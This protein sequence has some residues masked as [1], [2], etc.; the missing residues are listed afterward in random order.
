MYKWHILKI[1]SAFLLVSALLFS[2]STEGTSDFPKHVIIIGVDGMSP[3]GIRQAETPNMDSFIN[4]G[5]STFKA[6]AVLP[7]SS[8]TNWASMLMGAGPE[9]HG[10]TSNSWEKDDFV[11]PPVIS[12]VEEIFPTIFSVLHE[13]KPQ[14]EFGTV[15]D[16]GGF[17]RLFEKSIVKFDR[18]GKD[19]KETTK[20]AA[21]Y[22][23]KK[24][25]IYLFI[26]LDHVDHA[27]HHYGHGTP[28][29]YK[30][31]VR[32]DSLIGAIV[33]ATKEA[34]IFENTIFLVT[35][36]HGGIGYGHGGETQDEIEIPFILSGK[37]IK[38]NYQIKHAVY[39]YDNSATA[40]FALGLE[41][42]Y[43]WI[44]RPV[45]SAFSGFPE[46]KI[47]ASRQY[48]TPPV[49]F[50][51]KKFY[52]P[53]GGL[54][55]DKVAFAEIKADNEGAEIRYTLDG[56]EPTKES[57]L[58]TT[59]FEIKES[60]VLN[61]KQFVD[62]R[63]SRTASAFFRIVKSTPGNG[64]RYTYYEGKDWTRLPNF[65]RL[66][67]IHTGRIFEFGIDNIAHRSEQFAVKYEGFIKIDNPGTYT[68]YTNS[69]DGSQLRINK[70]LVVDNDGDHGV[71]MKSGNIELDKGFHAILV[72]YF[73]G[74][75]GG[76]LDVYFKG[77]GIPKQILPA[78]ILSLKGK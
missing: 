31:V 71:I 6:R 26:H 22:I 63:S 43:A 29:Y 17:G 27:G 10:I 5:A 68:F 14:A 28:E 61:A 19:E 56:T 7:T 42:P 9:Q 60:S 54:F 11:L 20:I 15:Y 74:G 33:Q 58:Y 4:N 23:K 51:A 44:G 69:D 72:T 75:G 21:E 25:P 3:D 76:W 65:N 18:N 46:P 78:N 59:K 57:A 38:K 55:V 50:P 39:T 77:P 53:A 35:A 36:D 34:G 37:G 47:Q 41:V 40:A 67:S 8:S 2:C 49:I 1:L 24:K 32:A 13:Q 73:N 16:W 12:G 30:S 66:R 62:D 48:L 70:K 64:I 52:S 45:K